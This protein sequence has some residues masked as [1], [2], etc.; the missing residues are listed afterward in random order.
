MGMTIIE[1]HM[2]KHCESIIVSSKGF[3]DEAEKAA[4]ANNIILY[5]YN[6]LL[7]ELMDFNSYLS[8]LIQNFESEP[9]SKL[10]IEQDFFPERDLKE[11]NSFQF[12]EQW[13]KKPDRKQ[14]SLLGDYGTGKT[15]FAKK[16]AYK[17]AKEYKKEP[18]SVRIPFLVDLRQCQKALSLRPPD[19]GDF[20]V[21]PI[22]RKPPF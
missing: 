4:E 12:V 13:L 10:Y 9:L 21:I 2:A 15:S 8:G 1:L 11:I 6:E 16:L 18:G 7:S 20:S 14:F 22:C 5:T 17:M 19:L 3:T